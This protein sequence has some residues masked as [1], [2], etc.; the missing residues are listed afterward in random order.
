MAKR[1]AT[2][3]MF[4][5]LQTLVDGLISKYPVALKDVDSKRILYLKSDAKSKKVVRIS[6][7]NVPHPSITTYR[8]V[9]VAYPLF[10]EVD[11]ARQVI[12]ILRELL[13]VEDFEECVLGKYKLQDFPEIVE[14]YGTTWEDR[15]DIVNPL[16]E[17]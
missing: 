10:E 1:K 11:E 14:K 15:E 8:F 9:L 2:V 12:H 7:I 16:E 3:E 5:Q 4:P 17:K 6:A 13:R